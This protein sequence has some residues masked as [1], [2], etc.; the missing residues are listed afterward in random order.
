MT[1]ASLEMS[2]EPKIFGELLMTIE[3]GYRGMKIRLAYGEKEFSVPRNLF[4]I[5]MMNTADRS[6][7]LIDYALRR[8]FSFFKMKPGFETEG[9]V[10]LLDKAANTKLNRLVD[11]IKSLNEEISKD[12]SLGEGFEIGHSYFCKGGEVDDMWLSTLVEYDLI[13]QLEEY[14]FDNDK[15]VEKWSEQLRMAIK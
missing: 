7:A 10:H 8:R 5:G 15:E 3:S 4:I 1:V 9:F 2:D 6:I 13:P 11:T 12:A 14:W